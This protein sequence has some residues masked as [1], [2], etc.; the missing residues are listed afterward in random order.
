[1]FNRSYG[2]S[3]YPSVV[4]AVIYDR[5]I[6]KDERPHLIDGFEM[7]KNASYFNLEQGTIGVGTGA[8]TGKWI[9]ENRVKG[10]FWYFD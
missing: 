4:G 8:T 10:G 3:K 2:L 6:G 5:K 1:M 9:Y 7:A